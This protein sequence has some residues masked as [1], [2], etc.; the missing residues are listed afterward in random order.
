MTVY[1]KRL[2][3]N[4]STNTLAKVEINNGF[5]KYH[6]VNLI[7]IYHSLV[8]VYEKKYECIPN[9]YVYSYRNGETYI[10][11]EN[12]DH[13]INDPNGWYNYDVYTITGIKDRNDVNYIKKYYDA[14]SAIQNFAQERLDIN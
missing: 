1:D 10:N 8:S 11:S 12:N 9:M 3:D 4:K 5:I 13:E 6:E 2:I 7:S 14:E